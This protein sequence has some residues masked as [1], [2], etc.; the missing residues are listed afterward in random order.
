M[1]TT[2][3]K[4]ELREKVYEAI[5]GIEVETIAYEGRGT[6]GALFVHLDT[7]QVFEITVVAKKGEFDFTTDIAEQTAKIEARLEAQREREAKALAKLKAKAEK[8]AEKQA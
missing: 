4:N 1:M 3:E 8:A 7:H 5:A 2:K 6:K